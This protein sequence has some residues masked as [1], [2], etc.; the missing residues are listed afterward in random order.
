[1]SEILSPRRP[2]HSE[3]G[4][5]ES[6]ILNRHDLVAW[7]C[8][9]IQTPVAAIDEYYELAQEVTRRYHRDGTPS[10][11]T[12][13][14]VNK[15]AAAKLLI[16]LL[17]WNKP[18]PDPA[19]AE[20]D[21]AWNAFIKRAAAEPQP[22]ELEMQ[23]RAEQDANPIPPMPDSA[24]TE[25]RS[26]QSYQTHESYASSAASTPGAPPVQTH[27]PTATVA[28]ESAPSP[29]EPAAPTRNP[30]LKMPRFPARKSQPTYEE[31]PDPPHTMRPSHDWEE[32]PRPK[33]IGGPDQ[34]RN[35]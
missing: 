29:P 35:R 13:K 14:S 3:D 4:P 27:P 30:A 19:E 16:T 22:W 17:G 2:R 9:A 11:V 23:R 32:P 31:E 18:E 12:V 28:P 15:L 33:A 5:S 10:Q 34:R 20:N 21:A 6:P 8:A 1:M 24:S 7:L 26:Y 25:H